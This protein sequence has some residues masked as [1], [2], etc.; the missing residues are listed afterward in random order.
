MALFGEKYGDWVRM[1]EVGEA[2]RASS[3]AA[4]TWRLPARSVSSMMP[5]ET[6]SASN[7]RRIEAVTGP[8]ASTL[9]RE[10]DGASCARSPRCCACPSPRPS[11]AVER[12]SSG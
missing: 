2:S 12:L 11:R 6:S 4:R 5:S 9:F 1:V 8:A 7:V 10:P 3:A